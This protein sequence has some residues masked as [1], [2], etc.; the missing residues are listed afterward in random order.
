[1]TDQVPLYLAPMSGVTDL[2][3]RLLA[4][5]CG[6]D[7]TITEFTSSAAISRD[8]ADSWVRL[9]GDEREKPFIPQIFGGKKDEMVKTVQLLQGR[10]DIIDLNFGCPATKVT[11][12]CAG[13]ALM[14][15]PDDLVE[16]VVA[17][18]E[19][20]EIPIT[21]KLR[22]GTGKGTDNVVEICRRLEDAGVYRL[23]VH[24]RTLKQGYSGIANWQTIAEVVESVSIPVIANGDIV[25]AATAK[26]CIEITGAAG[27]MVGRG[28]IGR[29]MI[30]DKIKRDMGWVD[31]PQPWVKDI[32]EDIWS[33][34]S[35]TRKDFL[36]RSWAW[37]RYIEL[38]KETVGFQSKWLTRHAVSFTKGLPGAREA[39]KAMMS[40]RNPEKLAQA[41]ENYLRVSLDQ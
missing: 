18:V 20:S 30:F 9:E 34:S 40:D 36:T 12:T 4:R 10:A 8:V 16:M 2:P 22:L 32:G 25:N 13:A 39:R 31:K 24:G 27:L 3:F 33:S 23:C 7:F 35:Q 26:E 21:A 15:K 17:C 1:M 29:P 6:A 28:A 11:R 14:G 5:E 38:C 19:A 41:V 37:N